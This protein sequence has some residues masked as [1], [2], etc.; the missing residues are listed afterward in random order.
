MNKYFFFA[1]IIFFGVIYF[2]HQNINNTQKNRDIYSSQINKDTF[3]LKNLS[4]QIVK[5]FIHSKIKNNKKIKI[6]CF[7]NSITNG[8]KVGSTGIVKNN[9]PL[10]LEKLLQ[11]KYKNDSI[12]VI[13]EGKNGRRIDQ[14]LQYLPK[15]IG[16]KPDVVI[17]EYGIN[18]A[19][20]NYSVQFFNQKMLEIFNQLQEKKILLLVASPTP[21]LTPQNKKVWELTQGMH[22]FCKENKLPFVNLYE[23]IEKIAK[24]NALKMNVLLPDKIHF[25]DEYY[26]YLAQ[27]IFDYIYF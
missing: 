11:K 23:G 10:E 19:Y 26:V 5:N 18:D 15:I 12:Q 4:N 27:I 1:A 8:F 3:Q 20:S 24:V 9:Y 2:Y 6:I 13:K 14:A 7:G 25:A 16:Q 22:Q 17:I 21:I